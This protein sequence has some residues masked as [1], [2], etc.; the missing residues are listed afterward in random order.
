LL[1]AVIRTVG[2]AR[3][4]S[5]KAVALLTPYAGWIAFATV[6]NAA[7]VALNSGPSRRRR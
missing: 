7:I 2:R 6:L 3:R 1:P 4:V 5:P